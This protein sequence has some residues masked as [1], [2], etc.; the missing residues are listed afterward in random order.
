MRK[1]R[2]S[3][4]IEETGSGETAHDSVV[5]P[6]PTGGGGGSDGRD[7]PTVNGGR[8]VRS[9]AG[10]EETGPTPC[11]LIDAVVVGFVRGSPETLHTPTR[12]R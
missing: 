11:P 8:P 12:G 4:L 1:G 5:T 6:L 10:T 7:P 2:D 9:T 3:V